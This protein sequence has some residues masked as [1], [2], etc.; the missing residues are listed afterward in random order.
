MTDAMRLATV[1][2]PVETKNVVVR[3]QVL[4]APLEIRL[5]IP[6]VE[7]A[8][9]SVASLAVGDVV[10]LYHPLERPLDLRAEGVLVARARQ[11]RS[12]ARVACSILEEV[13][14]R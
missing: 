4:R 6:G 2:E 1:S 9:Q 3:E 7:L 8:P 12:G 13:T 5:E 10:R 14:Q 11:G